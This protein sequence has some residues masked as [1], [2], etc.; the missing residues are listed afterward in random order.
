MFFFLFFKKDLPWTRSSVFGVVLVLDGWSLA[1][2]D[3]WRADKVAPNYFP[4]RKMEKFFFIL[5]L[6]RTRIAHFLESRHFSIANSYGKVCSSN[7]FL[8]FHEHPASRN[9][10][11]SQMYRDVFGKGSRTIFHSERS[12]ETITPRQRERISVWNRREIWQD[13]WFPRSW[14]RNV[15]GAIVSR[16]GNHRHQRDVKE[17]LAVSGLRVERRSGQFRPRG[18]VWKFDRNY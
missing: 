9:L 17:F 14:A 10:P 12:A 16:N 15:E 7:I 4:E 6:I 8:F 13:G 1:M 18:K 11:L 5:V 3:W 2:M